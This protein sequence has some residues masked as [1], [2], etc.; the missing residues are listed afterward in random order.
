M[1]ISLYS[2]SLQAQTLVSGLITDVKGEG[3]PGANIYLKDTYDD[4][5]STADGQFRFQTEETARQVL[6]VSAVGF[7]G[8][9]QAVDLSGTPVVL[10][11]VLKESIQKMNGVTV[12][13]TAFGAGHE[14]RAVAL[15]PLDIVTTAGAMGDITGALQ[16]LP[17]TQKVGEDGR[18]FIRGGEGYE[19]QVFIDGTRVHTPFCQSRIY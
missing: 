8:Y 14:A 15:Q 1:I 6:V 2:L 7:N 11:V 3:I 12:T 5:S 17:G 13:A 16:T 4:A 9:E 18:L 19:T 10:K